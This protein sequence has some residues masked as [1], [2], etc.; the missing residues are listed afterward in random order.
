MTWSPP[1]NSVTCPARA[2]SRPPSSGASSRWAPRAF[3]GSPISRTT[4]GA[5]QPHLGWARDTDAD[6]LTLRSHIARRLGPRRPAFEQRGRG[7][8]SE[9]VSHEGEAG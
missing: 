4:A 9:V 6:D 3:S 8:L 7:R 2:P 1:T 5:H